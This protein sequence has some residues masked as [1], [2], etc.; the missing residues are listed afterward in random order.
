MKESGPQLND[1]EKYLQSGEQTEI[2]PEVL[3]IVSHFQGTILEK[4][5]QI[6]KRISSLESRKFNYDIFRKRTGVQ[7][8][9]DNFDTGCTDSAL[10]FIT[11]ARASGIPTKYVETID[12][13]W[14]KE[15]GSSITGHIY[16][17]I[18]DKEND[19]WHWIDPMG[20]KIDIAPEVDSRI[21]F[22]EGLDSWN[23]GILD[24]KSLEEIFNKFRIGWLESKN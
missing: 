21:I 9:E 11:L 23:I 4:V 20:R 19:E 24:Y 5:D 6:I 18:Y 13:K 1:Q 17:Q 7:I 10:A 16:A 3:K 12:E 8:L 22:K 14:L 2:N 15:G